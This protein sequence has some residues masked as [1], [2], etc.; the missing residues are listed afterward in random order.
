MIRHD[1]TEVEFTLE[2]VFKYILLMG[3]MS[4]HLYSVIQNYSIFKI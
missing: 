3:S 4:L 2:Q 1:S